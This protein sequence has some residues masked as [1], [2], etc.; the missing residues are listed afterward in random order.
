MHVLITGST[1]NIGRD[2]TREAR[3]KGYTLRTFDHAAQPK[4]Q[5]GEHIPGDLRDPNQVRRAVQGMDAVVH[6][7]AIAHDRFGSAEDIGAVNVLGTWNLL[8]ACAEAGVQRVVFFSSVNAL[9]CFQGHRP[10][11]HLPIDDS[12]SHHPISPYQVSKH[13]G[14]E[15]CR[16]FSD[17]TGMTTICLR[18]VFVARPEF[19]A[20]WLDPRPGWMPQRASQDYWAYVDIRDVCSAT[21]RALEVEGVHHDS[22][23]LSAADTISD[24][25][26]AELVDAVYSGTPWTVDRDTYLATDPFR[27]LVDCSHARDV[28]GWTPAHSWRQRA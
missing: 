22:F 1:G 18:P 11:T 27:S 25:P 19:Y 13:V 10:A 12:Y 24:R 3:E 6:L 17:R 20:H 8:L 5:D 2:V 14:E 4:D 23:L 7:A 21:L 9:G 16:A 15:M 26:T 28:L